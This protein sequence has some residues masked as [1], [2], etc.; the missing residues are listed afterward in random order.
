MGFRALRE[1]I[2]ITLLVGSVAVLTAL[3]SGYGADGAVDGGC[4][5]AP[6]APSVELVYRLEAGTEKVAAATQ[7][8]SLGI[9]CAR[10]LAAG[11]GD[12]LVEPRGARHI[13]V[14]LP[15]LSVARFRRAIE[16]AGASGRIYFYDWERNLIGRERVIAGDPGRRPSAQ[17]LRDANREWTLAGR[18][19]HERANAELIA[20]GAL[21]TLY[22]A[23]ELA[24][25]QRPRRNCRCSASTLRLYLF[26]RGSPHRLLA[27][28]VDSHADLRAGAADR[29]RGGIVLRVPVGTT[30]VSELPVDA[31][32]EPE[33]D[34]EPAWFALRDSPELTG[35]ELAEVTVARD[36]F[37]SPV[38]IFGFTEQGRTAFRQVT[39]AIAR[40][41]RARTK[42]RVRASEAAAFSGHLAIV[43]DGVVRVRPIINFVENPNG[44][45]GRTGAQIS[46]AFSGIGEAR[47]LATMLRVGALPLNLT[48][49]RQH[50]P[51]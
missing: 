32:G 19:V 40:R 25:E 14:T 36:G 18:A 45:D 6:Q 49:V 38:V 20:A 43:I 12:A 34:A 47:G 15:Q 16:L 8:E 31:L 37:G 24:S 3:F 50:S 9:V 11:I 33:K 22:S 5:T 1:T 42:R 27:G 39:R 44:I 51:G 23:V 13:G 17:A 30:I 28:P 26:G 29:R 7:K 48:L 41:G 21:P 4:A 35:S 10:L 2:R 46:G